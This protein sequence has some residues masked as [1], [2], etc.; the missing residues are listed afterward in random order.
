MYGALESVAVLWRLRTYRDIITGKLPVLDLL[1]GQK[2]GFSPL[3][4]DSLHRFRPNFAGPTGIRVHLAVQNITSIGAGGGNAAP[5]IS[6][7][8]HFLVKSRPAG[9]TP[10]SD[11][12]NF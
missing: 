6:E 1:T 10:L 4:G 7:K 8:F 9:A 3:R 12:E 2:S 11:F 5:K